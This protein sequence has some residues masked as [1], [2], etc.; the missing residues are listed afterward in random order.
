MVKIKKV[1]ADKQKKLITFVT[2]GDPDYTTSKKILKNIIQ[3]GADI[4]EIGMP[5]TDPM[6]DG[7][8]IQASYLR[9]ISS[10]QN[11]LKTMKLVKDLCYRTVNKNSRFIQK[12][13]TAK[14]IKTVFCIKSEHFI[15]TQVHNF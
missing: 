1:F 4:I 2:G 5:F 10:G 9:A 8:G 13:S 15:T 12:S 3:N 14:N 11:L 6:A 7:P